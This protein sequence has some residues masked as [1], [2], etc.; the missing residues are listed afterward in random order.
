MSTL[1]VTNI[2]TTNIQD[3]SGAS[4]GLTFGS[5]GQ[6]SRN[7]VYAFS[8]TGSQGNVN[9]GGNQIIQFNTEDLDTDSCFNTGNYRFTAAVDG[10]YWFGG[11][12]YNNGRLSTHFRKNGSDIYGGADMQPLIFANHNVHGLGSHIILEL[13]AGDYV[14]MHFRNGESGQIYMGHSTFTGF[15]I[16]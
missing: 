4:G 8:A 12:F 14:T 6:V 3:T 11:H 5:G 13:D 9:Y 16:G 7:K 10:V 2:R 1:N 15:L